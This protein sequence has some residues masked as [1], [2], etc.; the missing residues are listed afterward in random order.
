MALH[1][2]PMPQNH[3]KYNIILYYT[4][5]TPVVTLEF[6]TSLNTS[7]IR[8][9]ADVYFECN[10]KSNPWVSKVRWRHNVSIKQAKN[11]TLLSTILFSILA[12]YILYPLHTP[13]PTT[14]IPHS[15]FCS[16]P[17]KRNQ[18]QLPLYEERANMHESTTMRNKNNE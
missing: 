8:E 2:M 5:D 15:H 17:L 6:G 1:S 18:N 11:H 9:G 12:P 14:H 10:I 3:I 13:H 4:A 16:L 7:S